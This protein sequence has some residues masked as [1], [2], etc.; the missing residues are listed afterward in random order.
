MRT[1]ESPRRNWNSRI[2][3]ALLACAGITLALS[4][5]A[6]AKTKDP[7]AN[8]IHG[9]VWDSDNAAIE[10]VRVKAM[11][12]KSKAAVTTDTNAAG[13]FALLQLPSG[14]YDLT[15]QKDG[16][17]FMLYP[18]IRVSKNQPISLDVTIHRAS[19]VPPLKQSN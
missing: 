7:T 5:A 19:G 12:E 9:H 4:L 15:F 16:F 18:H 1:L 14:I 6:T 8:G 11:N 17:E 10:G 13:E 2:I 3:S